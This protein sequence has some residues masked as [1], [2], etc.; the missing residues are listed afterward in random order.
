MRL[1]VDVTTIQEDLGTAFA[2]QTTIMA[3]LFITQDYLEH[4]TTPATS[5]S[6]A[7]VAQDPLI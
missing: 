1:E 6:P 4:N 5:L 7:Q 2:E 3:E